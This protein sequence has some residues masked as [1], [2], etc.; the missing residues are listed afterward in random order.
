[1]CL[2]GHIVTSPATALLARRGGAPTAQYFHANEIGHKPRLA[3]FAARTAGAS[4]VVSSYTAGL[5]AAVEPRPGD[6]RLIPPG[7]ALPEEVE[8]QP[9][10][11]PPTFVT[12]ARLVEPYKGHDVLLEALPA[13][14]A[15]VPDA[16]W[17]V[18]GDGPLRAPL[19]ARARAT[20]LG[21]A[22]RFLG[23]VPDTERDGWLA[24]A[25]V[26]AMPSR[27]PGGRLAGEGFGIVYLEAARFATPSLAGNVGGAVDAVADGETGLL[28]DPTDVAAVADALATL[29]A[30]RELARRLGAA[31]AARVQQFAWPVIAARVGALLHELAQDGRS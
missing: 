5:L 1:V 7:I 29:L 28:V 21:D 19:E 16:Q 3:A 25:D 20:G 15:R 18:I 14:R 13:V 30:D 22:V 17:V 12:V 2:S 9:A 4:I 27:L 8:A 10:G 26:F 23:S 11:G 6:V 31:A 24:R